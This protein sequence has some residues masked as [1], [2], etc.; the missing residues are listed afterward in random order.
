MT[1]PGQHERHFVRRA[2]DGTP[3][4]LYRAALGWPQRWLHFAWQDLEEL[5]RDRVMR[6]V[7]FG[8]EDLDEIA[9]ADVDQVQ[10]ALDLRVSKEP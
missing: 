4:A 8:L 10:A 1:P 2:Q 6:Q 3:R 7:Y 9:Q 5:A